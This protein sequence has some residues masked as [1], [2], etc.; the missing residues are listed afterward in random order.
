VDKNGVLISKDKDKGDLLDQ[1][2][3]N[4]GTLPDNATPVTAPL[5][6]RAPAQP[7]VT[8][9]NTNPPARQGGGTSGISVT[10]APSG[11]PASPANPASTTTQ[12]AGT[13]NTG[14][15]TGTTPTG[16]KP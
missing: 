13:S 10:P 16:T 11:A 5:N 7:R 9:A 1:V 8:P 6:R 3:A 15:T 2:I 12:P 14:T 4:Q